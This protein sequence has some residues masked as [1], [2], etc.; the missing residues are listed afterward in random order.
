[1]SFRPK[2]I[3]F[4]CYGTLT[5]FRMGDMGD[6]VSKDRLPEEDHA[7]F[8]RDFAAYRLDEVMGAWQPYADVLANALER[9]CK[10]WKIAFDP[11]EAR[12]IY[13]TVPTWGPWADVPAPLT[14]VG[15]EIPLV[16]LSNAMNS[17]IQANVDKLEAPFHAIYTAEQ[18]Q[19]Y[20]PLFRPF[21]YMLDMLDC[22]PEEIMHV[23][24]SYRYDLMPAR[25]LH[26]GARVH[27][28]RGFE[29]EAPGYG[30]AT[31]RDI[32]GLPGLVGL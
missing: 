9:T 1:M 22:A 20:K 15:K 23:S 12:T 5:N 25:D 30:T 21:E 2:Y 24:A 17:Q 3:T 8:R 7:A 19:A 27:V 16:I 14:K 31:I 28:N 26:F 10:K 6:M 13:E 32:S 29:P 4:D 11:A 18:A